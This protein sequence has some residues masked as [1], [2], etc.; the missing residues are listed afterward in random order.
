M[1][2]IALDGPS[3]AG[4]STVAKLLAMRSGI[5]YLDTGAMYRATAVHVLDNGGDVNDA[6]SVQ[7]LLPS[8]EIKMQDDAGTLKVML[9]SVDVSEKIRE[10]HISKAASDV[11][12]HHAVRLAL[13]EQQRQIASEN[14]CVLDGRD[15]G[16][17][18]LPNAKFKFYLTA[19]VSERASRRYNELKQKGTLNSTFEEIERDIAERDYQDMN[20]D[21]APLVQAKDAVL[22]DSTGM[23]IEEVVGQAERVIYTKKNPRKPRPGRLGWRF[24]RL[25]LSWLARLLYPTK[26]YGKQNLILGTRVIYAVANHYSTKDAVPLSVQLFKRDFN[27]LI[28]AEAY[29]GSHF[30]RVVGGIPVKRDEADI[31]AVRKCIEVLKGDRMLMIFPEGTRNPVADSVELLP[32]KSGFANL[33]VRTGSPVVP[34]LMVR[35]PKVFRKNRAIIGKPIYYSSEAG[36]SHEI[37]EKYTDELRQTFVEMRKNYENNTK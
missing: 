3:G 10:H 35:K 22:I 19:S 34:I 15:I 26:I 6:N 7:A 8:L 33:A 13:V 29:E 23:S 11:S 9:G 18:V 16:S 4:K 36:R 37:I 1:L 31:A 5:M 21:F 2:N 14:D 25:C 24:Y 17:F 20:R 30:L 32:F 12:K 28:K 27:V